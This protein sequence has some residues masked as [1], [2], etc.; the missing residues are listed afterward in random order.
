MSSKRSLEKLKDTIEKS[1]YKVRYEKGHFQS[2]SCLLKADRIIIINKFLDDEA[3]IEALQELWKD[4][5]SQIDTNAGK[6][7]N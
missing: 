5:A 1:G 6:G 3:K 7:K 2:G 4:I